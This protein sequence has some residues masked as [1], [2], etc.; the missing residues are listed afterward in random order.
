MLKPIKLWKFHFVEGRVDFLQL[1]RVAVNRLNHQSQI[2]DK[3]WSSS[4]VVVGELRAP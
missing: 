3:G 2:A 4:F 1:R